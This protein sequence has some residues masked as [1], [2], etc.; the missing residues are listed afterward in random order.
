M[1]GTM[2]QSRTCRTTKDTLCK[3]T[4]RVCPFLAPFLF[5]ALSAWEMSINTP[6][7]SFQS[8]D[9]LTV[10]GLCLVTVANLFLTGRGTM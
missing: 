6:V 1:N 3:V 5:T 9:R 7:L 2:A 10:K 8:C 4:L